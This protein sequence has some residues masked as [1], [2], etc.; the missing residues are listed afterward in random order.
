VEFSNES[1]SLQ[2][3]IIMKKSTGIKFL[4]FAVLAVLVTAC[5]KYE[6]GSKFTLLSKKARLVNTWT[7]TQTTQTIDATNT[8]TDL[9]SLLP[10][11]E[12][13]IKK[14]GTVTITISGTILG[15][16][17]TDVDNGTWA[18]NDDKSE[19]IFTDEAGNV[20]NSTIVMLKNKDLK[21]RSNENGIT[22]NSTYSG[23]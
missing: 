10:S 5:S 1:V 22:T 14:D 19:V 15:V 16:P 3:N 9:T 6:E 7:M 2:K 11:T 20:S 18:F 21:V 23:L 13:D 8:T 17:Y 12:V 4:A